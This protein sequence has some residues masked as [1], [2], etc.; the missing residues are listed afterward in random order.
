LERKPALM[1]RCEIVSNRQVTGAWHC[2]K[3]NAPG[4][5]SARPGQFV[6]VSVGA[7]AD[8]LLRRPISIH[9]VVAEKNEI[10][11]LVRPSGAGTELLVQAPPGAV[12]DLLGPLGNG[13]PAVD[14]PAPVLLAGGGI[15]LAPLY[16]LAGRRRQ[17]GLPFALLI[18]AASKADLPAREYFT[19]QGLDPLYAT[20]DG[21]CGYKGL[22]T[23][24]LEQRLREAGPPARI[25]ACG[26]LPMLAGVV[27]LGR[28]FAVPTDVSLEAH[29]ACGV[30]ACLG[31]A[32]PCK[33]NGRI[34]YRRVCKDG[35]VFNG[36]EVC[37]ES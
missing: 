32:F 9:H 30:G 25:Q 11:L 13:F 16:F 28:R 1:H 21:S 37:F 19:A 4:L 3:L 35:P 23:G 8:P 15:G 2:L 14:E 5:N 24:L 29:M 6:H 22:I 31:C 26:P 36:E 34:E 18:G 7:H 10:W 33:K 20:E 27:E 17:A 12:L